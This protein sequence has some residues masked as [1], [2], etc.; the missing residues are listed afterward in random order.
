MGDGAADVKVR[1]RTIALPPE[2]GGWGFLLEPLCLGLGVAPSWAGLGLA[3][4]VVSAFL[5]RHPLRLAVIDWRR[6]KRYART[7]L[8]EQ[9]VLLYGAM[10]AAGLGLAVLWAGIGMLWPL[11]LAAPLALIQLSQHLAGRG[12]E[13]LPELAGA[14]ALAASVA[15]LALAGDQPADVALALWAILAARNIPSILYV[16][17][18]LR[19]DSDRSYQPT[20]VLLASVLAVAGAAL[21]AAAGLAP[22]LSVV[23]LAVLLLR[24]VMGLSR[25]RR[26]VRVAVIGVQEIGYGALVVL[27]TLL[28]F[29]FDL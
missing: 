10:A 23:A 8:A 22:V 13:A 16:R 21:L 29:A 1:L 27:L 17:A 14:N 25:Y 19:L 26:R 15:S 24:A 4:A 5:G 2:H 28:G 7:R 9:F 3:A 18:R 20:P 6:K 11:L 12:R